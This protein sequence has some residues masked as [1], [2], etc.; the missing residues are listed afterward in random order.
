[1]PPLAEAFVRVGLD[2][3]QFER[4]LRGLGRTSVGETAGI[5]AGGQFGEAFKR[6]FRQ[7]LST[8]KFP[9][10]RVQAMAAGNIAGRQYASGFKGGFKDAADN[11][12]IP[13]NVTEAFT[14]GKITGAAYSRGMEKGVRERAKALKG[15]LASDGK[16]L[17]STIAG[18]MVNGFNEATKAW[19]FAAITSAAV[20]AVSSLTA[21]LPALGG[22]AMLA[23]GAVGL[24]PGAV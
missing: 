1:M 15:P 24:I 7:A 2:K 16:S 6:G 20:A 3:S 21:A 19:K 8:M 13:T 12:D 11:I 9:S 17:G 4:E 22:A 5:R 18:N 23:V 10:V 14:S